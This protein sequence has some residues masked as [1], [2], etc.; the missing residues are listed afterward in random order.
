MFSFFVVICVVLGEGLKL[1]R[2]SAT[3][4]TAALLE[5]SLLWLLALLVFPAALAPAMILV[6]LSGNNYWQRYRS[7][8]NT[9]THSYAFESEGQWDRRVTGV[10][11]WFFK[12]GQQGQC[13]S[14]KTCP[15]YFRRR[16]RRFFSLLCLNLLCLYLRTFCK[17]FLQTRKKLM[18]FF[19]MKRILGH[20]Y[21]LLAMLL[22]ILEKGRTSK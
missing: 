3:T 11:H 19:S 13:L 22:H 10:V 14:K 1:A 2:I 7:K 16:P 17:L 20:N 6:V 15:G 21:F 9:I 8:L 18:F 5:K 12:W 4:A